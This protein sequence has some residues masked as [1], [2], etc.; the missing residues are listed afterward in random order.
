MPDGDG[1]P[2][3][4]GKVPVCQCRRHK[5]HRFDPWVGNIPWRR[6][7]QPTPVFL[8]G[9]THGQTS[10]EGYSSWGGER[11]GYDLVTNNSAVMMT[12]FSVNICWKREG[13]SKWIMLIL[14][15][16]SLCVKHY[17]KTFTNIFFFSLPTFSLKHYNN[18]MSSLRICPFWRWGNWWLAIL[19]ILPKVWESVRD[20]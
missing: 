16:C 10:L 3:D 8:P 6:K 1:F 20:G 19:I 5:R 7:W 11:V 18:H 15:G 2:G 12:G 9:K 14:V 4:S 13:R 17:I